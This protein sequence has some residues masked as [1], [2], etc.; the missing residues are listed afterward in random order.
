[1]NTTPHPNPSHASGSGREVTRHRFPVGAVLADRLDDAAVA[2]AAVR[3]AT[4]RGVPLLLIAVL[5]PS[6]S[7]HTASRPDSAAARAVLGR[8]LPRLARAGIAHHPAAF[9]RPTGRA[10]GRLHAAKALLDSAA[11]HG[12]SRLVV[13]R[14]GPAELDAHTVMEAA[15]LRGTPFVHAAPPVPWVPLAAPHA[16][17]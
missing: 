17:R 15:A 14:S 9:H 6:P 13:S 16:S 4:A 11:A 1:M 3:L 10:R 2:D 5:P 7:G 12:C 8:A